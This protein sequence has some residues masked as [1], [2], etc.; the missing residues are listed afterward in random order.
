MEV[1]LGRFT[2][3]EASNAISIFQKELGE[4]LRR[5]LRRQLIENS[6]GYPW[7]LKKLCIHVYDLVKSETSQ[8]ELVDN[9]LD[10]ESLFKK[11]LQKLTA[12]E[13]ACLKMI[14]ERAP[15]DWYEIPRRLGPR[16]FTWTSRQTINYPKRRSPKSVLGYIP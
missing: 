2:S 6:Q 16:G 4:E 3:S 15:A 10:V 8:S 9:A 1:E 12:A 13:N 11:D 7:L 5:D 14:A